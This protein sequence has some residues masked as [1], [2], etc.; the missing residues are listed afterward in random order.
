MKARVLIMA[1]MVSFASFANAQEKQDEN[2]QVSQTESKT[3]LYAKKMAERLLLD[4]AKAAKFT[5][6]YQAYLEEKATC[7]PELV[8]GE[9]LTDAQLEANI[10]AMLN[11]REKAV[12]IDKKYYKKFSKLLNAKQLDMIMGP[13][14]QFGMHPMAA[15][16]G[17]HGMPPHRFGKPGAPQGKAPRMGKRGDFKK[18]PGCKKNNGCDKPVE[19]KKD[20]NCV[21]GEDCPKAGECKKGEACK[22]GKVCN[23]KADCKKN[24]NDCE[25]KAD[26]EKECK[27]DGKCNKV[28][29]CVTATECENAAVCDKAAD[30]QE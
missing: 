29:A 7:R 28:K 20:G 26:C 17:M 14:T 5:P 8:F 12:D 22:D 19:C 2:Q 30:S 6:L 11:V 18:A 27:Q 4:D 15:G 10:E 13:K 16:K 9:K 25:M 24:C 21:K 23:M 1:M 3:A